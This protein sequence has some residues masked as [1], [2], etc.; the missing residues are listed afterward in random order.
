MFE[1]D[2]CVIDMQTGSGTSRERQMR[3]SRVAQVRA[4][5]A[6]I[7]KADRSAADRTAIGFK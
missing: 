7:N 2:Q 5:A 6:E 1:R 4:E 3:L